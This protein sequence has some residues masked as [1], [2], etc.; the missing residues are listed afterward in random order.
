[1]SSGRLGP[2]SRAPSCRRRRKLASPPGPDS[3]SAALPMIARSRASHA[4]AVSGAAAPC[5]SPPSVSSL[6]GQA[7]LPPPP[8]SLPPPR[9][10]VAEPVELDAQPDQVLQRAGVDVAGDER[11]HRRVTRDG[12]GGVAV[13]PGPAAPAAARGG[14]GAVPGP[15]RPDPR[16]PLLQQRRAALQDHQV[17]EGDV[18]HGLDRL[19]GPLRQQPGGD[20]A[21]ASPPATRHGSAAAA[22]RASSAPAGADRASSTVA[23]SDAH[24]GVRSPVSTPAP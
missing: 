6:S 4:R 8:S 1:M 24:S 19:P 10:V 20:A 14:A 22:L 17:R 13:Q 18:H 21:A 9:R 2:P 7:S 3:R 16:R 23:T 5:A 12:L 11:D 15:L